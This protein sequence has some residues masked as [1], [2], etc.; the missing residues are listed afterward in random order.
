MNQDLKR[1]LWAAADKLRS[2]MDAAEYKHIILGL[3]F[4]KCIS[5]AFDE[6]RIQLKP[7][8]TTPRL[9]CT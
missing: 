5:D 3:I 1:T 8:S 2:S 7:S 6:R 4:I 9:T